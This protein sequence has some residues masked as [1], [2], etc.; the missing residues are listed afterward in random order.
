M[1]IIKIKFKKYMLDN[2][3]PGKINIWHILHSIYSIN[4]HILSE[5]SFHVQEKRKALQSQ[6]QPSKI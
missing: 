2:N 4:N 5:K 1:I 6:A 3:W